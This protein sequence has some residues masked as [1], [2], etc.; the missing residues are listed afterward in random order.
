VDHSFIGEGH[1]VPERDEPGTR[2]PPAVRANPSRCRRGD[3]RRMDMAVGAG[4]RFTTFPTPYARD[5]VTDQASARTDAR[6][7]SMTKT[8]TSV[9]RTRPANFGR[10]QC[11]G[12][13]STPSPDDL[14][15]A[16]R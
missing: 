13:S 3:T 7:A 6:P 10:G 8:S 9:R 2:A 11:P 16:P 1:A 15:V 4:D 14:S 5:D 12:S